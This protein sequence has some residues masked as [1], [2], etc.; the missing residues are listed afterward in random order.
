MMDC[1]DIDLEA[2]DDVPNRAP[3]YRD[4][5]DFLIQPGDNG[6]REEEP[7]MPTPKDGI[8]QLDV[9]SM[10]K[11]EALNFTPWL[12]KNLNLLGDALGMKL[13]PVQT[14]V[15]VKQKLLERP[16]RP[17]GRTR[18]KAGVGMSVEQHPDRDARVAQRQVDDRQ[19]LPCA[20]SARP[21]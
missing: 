2:D 18:A 19:L 21:A 16:R 10:W 4:R 9:R 11:H 6:M 17:G 3:L 13:E 7:A 12:A 1:I 20:V 5:R 14:E 15:P 8:E